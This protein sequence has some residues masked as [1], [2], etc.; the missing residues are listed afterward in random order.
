MIARG[1]EG[2]TEDL[3]QPP[4]P[5]HCIGQDKVPQTGQLGQQRPGSEINA[6]AGSV[7]S[8]DCRGDSVV[9]WGLAGRL[10]CHWPGE[11]S[12]NLCLPTQGLLPECLSA[13]RLPRL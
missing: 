12:A 9:F 5:G 6:S 10:W 7:P 1:P 11:A 3:K 8:E 13:T 2:R 4:G